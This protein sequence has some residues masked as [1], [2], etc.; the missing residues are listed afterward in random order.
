M[1]KW[2]D[3]IVAT[4][5]IMEGGLHPNPH[6]HAIYSLEG[7]HCERSLSPAVRTEHK[8]KKWEVKRKHNCAKKDFLE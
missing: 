8:E 2:A 1:G 6:F 5:G 4:G 7:S 3:S